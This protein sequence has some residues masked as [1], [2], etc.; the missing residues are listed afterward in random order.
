MN[1]RFEHLRVVALIGLFA[2]NATLAAEE[3]QQKKIERAQSLLQKLVHED[4][5]GFVAAGDTT[6]Q[7]VFSA[8]QAKAAWTSATAKL[9]RFVNVEQADVQKR[10]AY[11]SVSMQTRFTEGKLALRIVLNDADQLSGLWFDRAKPNVPYNPPAYVDRDRFDEV[12]VIVDAGDHPLP[13]KLARPEGD[14]SFPGLVLVHGSGPHDEDESIGPNKPFRDLAWGLAS[15]G[16][17]V[18]RYEKRPYRYPAAYPADQWTVDTATIDDAVA[19][20]ELLRKHPHVD[21][22]RVFVLGHSL[23]AVAAP[24]IA[25]RAPEAAGIILLAGSPRSLLDMIGEQVEYLA[26]VDGQYS[27]QER[28][29]VEKIQTNLEK[30]RHGDF[31]DMGPVIGVPA[32]I[33][34]HMHTA[35]KPLETARELEIPILIIHGGRDYQVTDV[36]YKAWQNGLGRRANVR[37]ARFQ[38]LNHLM[39]SGS[40]PS[41]PAE[42]EQPGHVDQHVIQLLIKWIH[43]PR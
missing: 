40:G 39:I 19:A 9:G 21:P 11:W 10:D 25:K 18:L 6:M 12:D 5:A 8:E 16:V 7:R 3:T 20:F 23:G 30:I 33:L 36:D 32:K 35:L 31:Q 13:A 43:N 24:Q 28:Q 17:A 27:D 41:R 26:K 2:C 34:H 15:R 29:E 1:N 22:E 38:D 42:Y 14:R 37:F 4:Y